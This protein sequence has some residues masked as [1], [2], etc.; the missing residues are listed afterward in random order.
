MDCFEKKYIEQYGITS[1]ISQYFCYILGMFAPSV[2]AKLLYKKAFLDSLSF[3]SPQNLNEKINWL[4]FNTDTLVWTLLADKL[5]VRNYVIMQGFD[6][7]LTKLYGVWEDVDTID[8]RALPNSFVLKCNH[9]SGSAQVVL[10]KTEIKSDSIVV[11]LKERMKR[12]YG[13]ISAEP[14]YRRIKRYVFAE[15]LIL[16]VNKTF[17]GPIIYKFWCFYGDVA[18][19][20]VQYRLK[21][22]TKGAEM[23]R[24]PQW[25][26]CPNALISNNEA[27]IIH[28]PFHLNEMMN[29][30]TNLSRIFPQCRVDMY[31]TDE[32]IF[33][34]ELTF[35]A[36]AG[37][38][39]DYTTEFLME[40]GN[41]VIITEKLNYSGIINGLNHMAPFK[42][43]HVTRI[44]KIERVELSSNTF[45]NEKEKR[46]RY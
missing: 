36:G 13:I 25:Q 43:S 23:Y 17:D 30:A 41:R 4:E 14:H 27:P 21:N 10:D 33:F 7:M 19:C 40:L 35:T 5:L 3:N 18:F 46:Y 39:Y 24:L 2:L 9:D 20:H 29:M 11:L 8:F 16:G 1:A 37:R 44:S 15:E 6:N 22:G 42:T 38:L 32:R 45:R 34:G 31:E 12:P 26:Y 28:A